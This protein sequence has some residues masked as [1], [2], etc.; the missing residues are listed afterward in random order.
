MIEVI[1]R[2]VECTLFNFDH[3][4]LPLH[5]NSL[6]NEEI[7][8]VALDALQRNGYF[9]HPESLLIAL[10]GDGDEQI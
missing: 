4:C 9:A 10:L 6:S 8:D 3:R 7:R 5:Y 1:S 2:H